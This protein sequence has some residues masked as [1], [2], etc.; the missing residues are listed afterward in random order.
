MRERVQERYLRGVSR[1]R[2]KPTHRVSQCVKAKVHWKDCFREEHHI[3]VIPAFGGLGQEVCESLSSKPAQDEVIS[4]QRRGKLRRQRG[5]ERRRKATPSLGCI[6]IPQPRM[7][8]GND[9]LCLPCEKSL[10]V[11]CLHRTTQET[12]SHIREYR[13]LE[14]I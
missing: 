10:R 11:P 2:W 13:H 6:V 9:E 1:N 14:D 5:G 12:I 7:R 8:Q 4:K 3:P